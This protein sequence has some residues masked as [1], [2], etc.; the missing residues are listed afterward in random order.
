VRTMAG[1][2]SD[3]EAL[4]DPIVKRVRAEEAI[5]DPILGL[6]ANSMQILGAEDQIRGMLRAWY[7]ASPGKA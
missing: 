2:E 3:V 5:I 6:P 1:G 4:L 7:E